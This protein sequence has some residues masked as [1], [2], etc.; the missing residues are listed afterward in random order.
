MLI[1][2]FF[3]LLFSANLNGEPLSTTSSTT[4]SFINSNNSSLAK[5]L[6]EPQKTF[7]EKSKG[8]K[9]LE[10]LT[11]TTA[12]TTTTALPPPP[13]KLTQHHQKSHEKPAESAFTEYTHTQL[14][15]ILSGD[16][17]PSHN[18]DLTSSSSLLA[19]NN[20]QSQYIEMDEQRTD[21]TATTTTITS[22]TTAR[23]TVAAGYNEIIVR[24]GEKTYHQTSDGE[25]MAFYELNDIDDEQMVTETFD[26]ENFDGEV[27]GECEFQKKNPDNPILT[28]LIHPFRGNRQFT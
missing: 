6:N 22:T 16:G 27:I 19:K 11:T 3:L 7:T 25:G 10:Y 9:A 15:N 28:Y 23:T 21:P 26:F 1:M 2:F 14:E 4:S 17:S 5:L 20:G 18:T 24:P 13:R 12:R 8:H